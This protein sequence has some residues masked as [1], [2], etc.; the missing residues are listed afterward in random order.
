[1]QSQNS[2]SLAKGWQLPKATDGV[3]D[4]MCKEPLPRLLLRKIHPF[5]S[6]GEFRLCNVVMIA[7]LLLLFSSPLS[8][9]MFGEVSRKDVESAS[10][11]DEF[12]FKG[13]IGV[14]AW[15]T[16]L[17]IGGQDRLTFFFPEF[18]FSYGPFFASWMQGL[19]AFIPVNENRTIL[20]A[21]A[22]RW[23]L[24]RNLTGVP[25]GTVG[26][27]EMMRPVATL[28]SIILVDSFIFNFRMSEGMMADNRGANY[29]LGAAWRGKLTDKTNIDFYTTLIYGDRRYNTVYFGVSPVEHMRYGFDMHNVGA[30][31]QSVD[32]G[33]KIKHFITD[34]I[35]M[36]FMFEYMRLID[37]AARSPTTINRNQIIF[38]VGATYNF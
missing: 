8:A 17:Y 30:G 19:G 9:Q 16:P 3:V 31:F 6:E 23:R 18:D 29:N 20:F 27:M 11:W 21:P 1:M 2:P 34:T 32:F 35:A 38:S 14:A 28:N 13:A 24:A 37:V 15:N 25:L 22:V 10:I 12:E 7:T 5:A 26:F 36:D 4:I 33:T